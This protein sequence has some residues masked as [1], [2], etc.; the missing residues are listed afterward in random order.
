MGYIE[1]KGLFGDRNVSF[2]FKKPLLILIGE[3]G[4]GKSTVLGIINNI[5]NKNLDGL[6]EYEFDSITF[7]ISDRT[8]ALNKDDFNSIVNDWEYQ[9]DFINK[10]TRNRVLLKDLVQETEI[11]LPRLRRLL[12]EG[13]FERILRQ[14]ESLHNKGI[15]TPALDFFFDE[16]Y[17]IRDQKHPIINNF[18]D[19]IRNYFLG[20]VLYFPTY[21]RVE[22]E[23]YK[24]GQGIERGLEKN[25]IKF[26]MH[27]VQKIF[28]DIT[29]LIRK[30]TINGVQ[31]VMDN[32]FTELVSEKN[33]ETEYSV[34]ELKNKREDLEII[35]QRSQDSLP[36]SMKET[37]EKIDVILEKEVLTDKEQFILYFISKYLKIYE[38]SKIHDEKINQFIK[39]CNSYFED[40]FFIYDLKEIQIILVSKFDPTKTIELR[41]LSSGE[42][43]IV[44]LFAKLYLSGVNK[45][46]LLFDEPELSLSIKWQEK[47]LNNILETG[48]CDFMMAVTHS[49]FIVSKSLKE[50]TLSFGSTIKRKREFN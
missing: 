42:K 39:V 3:N 28:K 35:L 1:I 46:V 4:I 13:E 10:M 37:L 25:I 12:N 32:L 19:P 30:E 43:Q 9:E 22:E 29:D 50:Y 7:R 49:P 23:A 24:L 44:S 31:N 40:K 5:L 14:R 48:K 47:L 8:Y 11:P 45:Y 41:S 20:E 36:F 17:S 18:F 26:G 38:A 15:S 27:D 6:R 33:L 34:V 2:R 16:L 21:R